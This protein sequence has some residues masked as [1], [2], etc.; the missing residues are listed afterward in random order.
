MFEQTIEIDTG[1]Y[2]ATLRL[3]YTANHEYTPTDRG[4]IVGLEIDAIGLAGEEH[5][6]WP[7][8]TVQQALTYHYVTL[9]CGDN[10]EAI[11]EYRKWVTD[12][13]IDDRLEEIA[14]QLAENH[15][16]TVASITVD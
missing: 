1:D 15:K 13:I 7:I 2:L 5:E 9:H 14:Q 11:A 4:C 16:G 3:S 6:L 10:P 12:V 8:E